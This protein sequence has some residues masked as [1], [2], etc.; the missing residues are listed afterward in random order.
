MTTTKAVAEIWSSCA[1]CGGDR[2]HS[3]LHSAQEPRDEDY[4]ADVLHKLVKCRGCGTIS[5]RREFHDYEAGWHDENGEWDYPTNNTIYPKIINGHS[6]IAGFYFVPRIVRTIYDET[7]RSIKEDARILAGLG[8]RATIEAICNDQSITGQT[9]D[10]RISKLGVTGLISK[11]D[12]ERLHAIRFLG[13]DAAHEIKQPTVN[14]ISVA[15]KIVDHLITALYV[16]DKEIDGELDTTI[17]DFDKFN[18]LIKSKLSDF[19]VGDEHS[20]SRILG[21]DVRRIKD[22]YAK[23]ETDLRSKITSGDVDYLEIGQI[24]QVGNPPK[25]IQLY[26]IT[27]TDA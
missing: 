7:I 9:L 3:T 1:S 24:E 25:Q 13:N 5:Y 11:K 17:D 18:S 8:L 10:K 27:K 4:Q 2:K 6:G 16:L 21:T 23:L 26:K 15:L 22:A 19:N 14:Q 20:I 12:V